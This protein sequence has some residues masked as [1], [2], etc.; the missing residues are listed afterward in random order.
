MSLELDTP[1]TLSKLTPTKDG[2]N[3]LSVAIKLD[4]QV[5]PDVLA[6]FD[7]LLRRFLFDDAGALPR[8]PNMEPVAWKGEMLNM[9]LRID[10]ALDVRDATL[11]KFTLSPIVNADGPRVA[12]TFQA[13]FQ[14]AST[15]VAMLTERL[16][17][18][19]QLKV[20]PQPSLI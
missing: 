8:F 1:A 2:D 9:E 13:H 19:I 5:D 11:K 20:Q 17:E 14:P 3:V 18:C 16:Q 6:H 10:N 15:E 4:M 12:M 7:P